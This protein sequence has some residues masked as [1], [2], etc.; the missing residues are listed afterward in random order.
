MSENSIPK[1][2]PVPVAIVIGRQFGSGGRVI[3]RLV[4]SHLGIPYYDKELLSEAA[5]KMGFAPEV[6]AKADEKPPSPLRSLLQGFYG[7]ADNF[8]TGSYYGE[9]L[10]RAQSEVIRELA[11]NQSCVF[12]GRTADY[13]LRDHPGLVSVF[14]HAPS[15]WR[16]ARIVERCESTDHQQAKDMARRNDRNREN[17]YNYFTGRHW[18]RASNYHLSIDS[19]LFPAET[20]ADMIVK[21]AQKRLETLNKQQD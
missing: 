7:V 9:G 21:F 5:Q 12:V 1:Q 15:D 4:A 11:A 6:F 10:Y 8:H 18:G 17:F 19:S 16:A 13:V 2:N 14:L 20:V 3:G